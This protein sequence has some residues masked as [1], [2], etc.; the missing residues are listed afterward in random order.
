MFYCT[1]MA[2]YNDNFCGCEFYK[3]PDFCDGHTNIVNWALKEGFDLKLCDL[4][5]W[6]WVR[7]F[8]LISETQSSLL[9]CKIRKSRKKKLS[10]L[11]K[12]VFLELFK[13]F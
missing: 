5:T 13:Y 4:E 9:V 11:Q 1:K 6:K 3:K 8:A 2:I 7:D 10:M 12:G